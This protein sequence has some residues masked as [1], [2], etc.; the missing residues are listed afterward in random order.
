M[1]AD[2]RI[3]DVF[4]IVGKVQKLPAAVLDAMDSWVNDEWWN[5][6]QYLPSGKT[7]GTG[8]QGKVVVTDLSL[9]GGLSAMNRFNV[10]LTGNGAYLEV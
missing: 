5:E 8:I 1:P 4:A 3:A 10:Q 9:S 7:D 2:D 6:G